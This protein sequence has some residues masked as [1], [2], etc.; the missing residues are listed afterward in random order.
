MKDKI[1]HCVRGGMQG[2]VVCLL[3]LRPQAFSLFHPNP[4]Y[5]QEQGQAGSI[6]DAE[7]SQGM[8]TEWA[9]G[10]VILPPRPDSRNLIGTIL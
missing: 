2:T 7:N 10:C 6:G 3:R 9:E 8:A 1:T 4:H 5:A